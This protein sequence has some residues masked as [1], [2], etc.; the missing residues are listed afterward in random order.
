MTVK[1]INLTDD[2][3]A[4]LIAYLQ[5]PTDAIPEFMARPA[6][7]V[8]PGGGY[9]F[10]SPREADPIALSYLAAGFHAFV[11]YYSAGDDVP[12]PV[13]L[14]Q[15]SKA[16]KLIRDNSE[17][18]GVIPDNIAVC[19]FSAGGH[20]CASLGTLWNHPVIEEKTGYKNGENKPDA[21]ILG[22]PVITTSWIENDP[23]A[24]DRLLR[25]DKALLPLLS[26]Q[27][28]V[29]KHTPPAFLFHTYMDNIVPVED[30]LV[31]GKALAKADIPFEMHIFKD[32][33]HGLSLASPLTGSFD[34]GVEG[35]EVAEWI[36]MSS[37]WLWR[38][39]GM[40]RIEKRP[41]WRRA[42]PTEGNR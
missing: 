23:T 15:L 9:A 19:G 11:L 27:N 29:G 2:G 31:F 14:C 36:K 24:M 12:F 18:W 4:K 13:P 6:V 7:V 25:E 40:P 3:R 34:D 39:F 21:L 20:L 38:V 28:F 5:E 22:Y 8:C 35:S 10:C 42:Y 33:G 17:E 1:T 32:G 26:L 16:M 30:S 41:D 37:R